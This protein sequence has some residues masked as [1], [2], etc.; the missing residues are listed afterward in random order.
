MGVLPVTYFWKI[1]KKLVLKPWLH[2]PGSWW[3]SREVFT[4]LNYE[5][6][7]ETW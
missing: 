3:K 4:W 6:T 7:P 2:S 1:L 5:K